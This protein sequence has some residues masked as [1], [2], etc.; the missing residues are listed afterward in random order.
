MNLGLTDVLLTIFLI[1]IYRLLQKNNNNIKNNNIKNNIKNNNLLKID[2]FTEI[3]KKD[4]SELPI[5][6]NN[7]KLKL[8]KNN[9]S[10]DLIDNK[11]I[12]KIVRPTKNYLIYNNEKY[13][14]K[15]LLIT[16]YSQLEIILSFLNSNDNPL[17]ITIPVIEKKNK[18]LEL[19]R[20]DNFDTYQSGKYL[21]KNLPAKVQ[22][23]NNKSKVFNIWFEPLI[24][25]INSNKKLHID[26]DNIY[27]NYY[28]LNSKDINNIINIL[29]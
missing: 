20:I 28:Y 7:I 26:K 19:F 29:E 22:N 3:K 12:Y 6:K 10:F 15:K 1:L 5:I 4:I 9:N 2:T 25:F 27:T 16:N 21:I 23:V 24:N 14:L 13:Y 17:K 8:S 18:Y 11:L